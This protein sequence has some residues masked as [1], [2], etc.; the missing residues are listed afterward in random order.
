MLKRSAGL[1]LTC[2]GLS[3]ACGGSNN[4]PDTAADLS[5]EA[6]WEASAEPATES[7]APTQS[8]R[9]ENSTQVVVDPSLAE[10]CGLKEVKLYFPFDSAEVKGN[11]DENVRSMADCLTSGN[12]RGKEL[13]LVGHTDPRGTDEY[14]KALGKSRADSIADL[15]LA[16]GMPKDKLVVRSEG[17][18][19]ASNDQDDWPSDRRVDVGLVVD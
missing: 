17:E 1:I 3:A 15:L 7:P 2:V 16:A 10:K 18:Q 14:N 5:A 12:L 4:E 8:V 13:V 9:D 11:G 6:E 19:S